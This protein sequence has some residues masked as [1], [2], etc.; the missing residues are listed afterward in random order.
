MGVKIISKERKYWIELEESMNKSIEN[1]K[2]G[3]EIDNIVLK[4]A[5]EKIE[6]LK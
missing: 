5:K 4:F 3:L 2:R 1:A 6:K